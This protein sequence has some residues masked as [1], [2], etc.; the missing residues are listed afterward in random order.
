MPDFTYIVPLPSVAESNETLIAK[1]LIR[2]LDCSIDLGD[3]DLCTMWNSSH[4]PT[5]RDYCN[6]FFPG[7][8]IYLQRKI[9]AGRTE[10]SYNYVFPKVINT[11]TGEPVPNP[12]DFLT[13]EFGA[14]AKSNR[15]VN[16]I[17]DTAN[18]PE[19]VTCFYI[20]L[21]AF[22]CT[23]RGDKLIAFNSCVEDLVSAGK[24]EAEAQEICLEN[25]CEPITAFSEPYCKINDCINTIVLEGQYPRVD[26]D[27]NYYGPFTSG[28]PNSFKLILRTYGEVFRSQFDISETLIN[29]SRRKTKLVDSYQLVTKLVPEYVAR[30]V[31]VIFA[32]QYTFVDGIQYEKTLV[33]PKN[34][35]RGKMW[36]ITSTITRTCDEIDFTCE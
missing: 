24:T 3:D 12:D 15:Y 27:G 16:L 23:L 31:A 8:V 5:D 21:K 11:S 22:S 10:G 29:N 30:I 34:T 13:V 6:P 20:T 19:E 32:A 2:V 26:C 7:D 28:D 35:E 9:G 33:V 14:D 18:L 1:K 25:Y 4:C 17:I 36:Q